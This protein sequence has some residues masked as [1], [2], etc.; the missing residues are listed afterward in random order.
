MTAMEF[1]TSIRF[2]LYPVLLVFGLALEVL[3]VRRYRVCRNAEC[4][5]A[6]WLGLGAAGLGGSGFV[7]LL[8]AQQRGFSS[9]TSLILTVGLLL[10]AFTLVMAVISL[11]LHD[12]RSQHHG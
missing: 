11:F 2:L 1:W 5:W 7:S 9:A 4:A 10:M 6:A 12:W 3:M 8:I